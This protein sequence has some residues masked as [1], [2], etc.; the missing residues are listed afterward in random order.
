[1]FTDLY[2]YRLALLNYAKLYKNKW[3]LMVNTYQHQ[4]RCTS[5]LKTE[6]ISWDKSNCD[7]YTWT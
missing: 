7:R 2:T 6:L 5:R 4:H 3:I 1:M